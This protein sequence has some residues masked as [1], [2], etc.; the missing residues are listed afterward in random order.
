MPQFSDLSDRQL[1][2]IARYIHYARQ[3]RRYEELV[4]A[5]SERGDPGAGRMYFAQNCASCHTSDLEG[6][7][8]KYDVAALRSQ[9]LTAA[10]LGNKSNRSR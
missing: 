2:D 10:Q 9:M 8:N 4:I 1:H 3:Q 5:E 7:G 6:I